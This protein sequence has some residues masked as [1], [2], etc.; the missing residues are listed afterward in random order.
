M[1][2]QLNADVFRA[3]VV[4]L[5]MLERARAHLRRT[6]NLAMRRSED[7]SERAHTLLLAILYCAWLEAFFLKLVHTPYGFSAG[8]VRQIKLIQ[9]R[10]GIA[11]AWDKC[12]DLA[13][14]RVK[15]GSRSS[16]LPNVSL[17][18]HRLVDEF[19][20]RPALLRNKIAH[21]Q[22]IA[23]LNRQNDAVNREITDDLSTTDVVVIDRWCLAVTHLAAVLEACIES[24]NRAFRRDYWQEMTKLNEK[25]ANSETWTR[26]TRIATLSRKPIKI[27][28]ND[29]CGDDERSPAGHSPGNQSPSARNLVSDQSRGER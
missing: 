5:R 29:S 9:S 27:R 28:R 7:A 3:Q 4:N 26:E 11:A 20:R 15:A 17:R 2:N 13:L 10:D 21:G 16:Y 8:E 24:P 18:L 25:L 12:I 19:V 22:W 6:I 1:V 14:A 23:A